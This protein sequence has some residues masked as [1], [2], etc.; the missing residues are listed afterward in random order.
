MCLTGDY[1]ES[2][3]VVWSTYSHDVIVATRALTP[4]LD[5]A[6]DPYTVNEFTSVGVDGT[7]LFWLLDETGAK[8]ELNVHEA[9]VPDDLLSVHHM[10]G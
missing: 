9:E 5:L 10:V 2:S 4:V 8:A 6:W 1:H 3:I 7:M